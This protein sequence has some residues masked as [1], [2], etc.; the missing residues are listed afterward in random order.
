M[1]KLLLSL[2]F[3][4]AII[5]SANAQWKVGLHFSPTFSSGDFKEQSNG[6]DFY[7]FN[8]EGAYRIKESPIVVGAAFGY[9][10]YG[11]QLDKSSYIDNS[12][13]TMRVRT[14]NN[15]VSNRL[16]VRL[17]PNWSF[18][19]LPYIEAA[20]GYN[21]LYTRETVRPRRA[22]EVLDAE[23]LHNSSAFI[24]GFGGGLAIP[25]PNT[26]LSID[27]RANY[28]TGQQTSYLTK[29]DIFWNAD[30][31]IL[32]LNPRTST[33]DMLMFQIGLRIDID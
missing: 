17:Q 14:N 31:E 9:S 21:F 23:T 4:T 15:M 33:T 12:G 32:E 25:I 11:S 26:L 22:S 10:L 8:F 20:A 19:V 6:V 3:S 5:L 13:Q 1:A 2:L 28:F 30:T 7:G 24:Y 27:L 16:F 29:N 18:F